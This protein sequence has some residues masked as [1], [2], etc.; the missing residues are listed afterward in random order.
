METR[1]YYF[2]VKTYIRL[3][4]MSSIK[5]EYTNR[6][7]YQNKQGQ[8]HRTDGP[9][10]EYYDGTISWYL[11]GYQYDT[12]QEHQQEVIRIKLERLKNI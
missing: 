6:I 7:E 8:R 3:I 1:S 10:I 2:K 12:E 5:I 11:Y 9:A 4:T